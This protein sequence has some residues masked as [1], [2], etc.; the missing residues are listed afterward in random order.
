MATVPQSDA[1]TQSSGV[2]AKL[3]DAIREI[4]DPDELAYAAAKLLGTSLQVSRVGYGEIDKEHETR[5]N[6]I[7]M[8]R[9]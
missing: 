7:G 3:G 1:A 5:S 4:D 6:A 8:R 2:L 9:A